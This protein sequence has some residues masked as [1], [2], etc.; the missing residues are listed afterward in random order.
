MKII[1]LL[2]GVDISATNEERKFINKH[3]DQV[4]ILSLDEHDQWMAQNLV[5]K[6]IYSISKDSRSI[7]KNVDEK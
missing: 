5:R 7:I 2:S 1:H 3:K 4:S 6:G